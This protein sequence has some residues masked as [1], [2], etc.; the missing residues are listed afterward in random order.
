MNLTRFLTFSL[1]QM[2]NGIPLTLTMSPNDSLFHDA[3]PFPDNYVVNDPILDDMGDLHD[4]VIAHTHTEH[5]F[6]P[7]FALD[8]LDL[9]DSY[10]ICARSSKPSAIKL[11]SGLGGHFTPK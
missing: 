10:T 6:D 1:S 11:A 9:C 2:L 7:Y 5:F 8:E 4:R 3:L